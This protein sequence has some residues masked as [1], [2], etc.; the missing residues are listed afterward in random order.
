MVGKIQAP[1]TWIIMNHYILKSHHIYFHSYNVSNLRNEN[2]TE[3]RL[4]VNMSFK[5]HDIEWHA[6]NDAKWIIICL[7]SYVVGIHIT[8]SH[9]SAFI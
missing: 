3:V 4:I 9:Q 1:H 5:W 7:E 2:I 8:Q 6:P